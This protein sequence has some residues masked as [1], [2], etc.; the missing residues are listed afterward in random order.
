MTQITTVGMDLA[1]QVFHVVGFAQSGREVLKKQLRRSQVERFF[2]KLPQCTVAVEACAGAHEW[3]R[4]LEAIGHRVKLVPPK[5]V[6]AF[7]DGNKNDYIDARAIAEASWSPRLRPVPV[8]TRAQQEWQAVHRFREARIRQRT[9]LCNQVRGLLAEY[10]IVLP[11]GIATVRRQ[12][13]ALLEDAGNGLGVLDREMLAAAY[14]QL[15]QLDQQ[16]ARF[17]Q[18]ISQQARQ[19][20]A[21]KALLAV[22]GFGPI[23]ASA[24]RGHVGDGRA[25]RRGRDV[26][27]S[28]GVVPAQHSTGGKARLLG[29][30]KRG[31]R[32]LRA[33]LIH[34][35]RSVVR[36]AG[37]KEDALS[38]WVR[39][40]EASRGRN[41]AVVALANKLARIGWAVLRHD[42]A[43]D[44]SR[45]V[46]A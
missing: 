14:E 8:K 13:P 9:A 21:L 15:K 20:P 5:F 30:S 45:A 44:P 2:A 26:A 23:V 36:Q 16:I 29:I 41:K 46:T 6:K 10:G 11:Q 32:Y 1:K 19:D 39:R 34:G 40:V 25:F 22:P 33:K 31:D 12:I 28:L 43:Y 4:R 42:A 18:L 38:R 35:A 37:K 17:E 3:G 27:A 7:V 24:F